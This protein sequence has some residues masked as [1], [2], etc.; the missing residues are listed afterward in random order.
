M[1]VSA[2]KRQN[3]YFRIIYALSISTL[4]SILLL[5]IGAGKAHSSYYLFLIYNMGLAYIAPLLALWLV[6]RLKTTAWLSFG[7]VVL[8]LLWLGFLPNSFYMV[9]DLIH[10]QASIGYDLLF[11]I[12]VIMLCIFNSLVAAYI[13]LYLVHWALL[14]RFYYRNVHI[15]IGLVILLCSFAIYLGRY[16]RWNSWDV[17]VNPFGL[18]FDVSDSI[19]SPSTHPEV[20]TT[21]LSF[22]VLLTSMYI[23]IWQIARVLKRPS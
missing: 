18:L 13:S 2:T 15:V 3:D 11:N 1:T 19:T 21:T 23:V 14:K 20:L 17:I 12:V 7:N 5:L 6:D 8:S 10:A 16:L 4:A 9:T 22:F